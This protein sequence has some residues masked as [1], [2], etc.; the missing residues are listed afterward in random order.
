MNIVWPE[1]QVRE[2]IDTIRTEIGRNVTFN[3]LV[4][5]IGCSI[6][7]LDPIT[8][9]STN[10]FCPVCHGLYWLD[11]LS[12]FTVSGHIRWY[13]MDKPML[14]AGGRTPEGDCQV[15]IAYTN[16]DLL[17]VQNSSS[18][19]VDGKRMSLKSY[20]LKGVKQPNRIAVILLEEGDQNG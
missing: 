13:G 5:G 17:A 1:M 4:S 3:V 8:N 14:Q 2:T 9:T 6:C 20:K 16:E 18:V 11:T 10:S 12:G 15:T 7:S 19:I